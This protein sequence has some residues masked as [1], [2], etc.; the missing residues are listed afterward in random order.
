MS[1]LKIEKIVSLAKNLDSLGEIHSADALEQLLKKI[2]DA[3][4]DIPEYPES[5]YGASKT[6]KVPGSN[7]VVTKSKANQD[8]SSDSKYLNWKKSLDE[9]TKYL[10]GDIPFSWGFYRGKYK[11][12]NYFVSPDKRC[13]YLGK[14]QV[15]GDP[16]TYD[17]ENGK[18]KVISSPD[19][20]KHLIGR[21]FPLD[22]IPEKYLPKRS[23]DK[24]SP[25]ES[26]EKQV[27]VAKSLG[28]DLYLEREDWEEARGLMDQ[29]PNQAGLIRRISTR[30]GVEYI[31]QEMK[32]EYDSWTRLD[33][34][35]IK[36]MNPELATLDL[37]IYLRA[38]PVIENFF[39]E[40]IMNIVE[41]ILTERL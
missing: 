20:K 15:P 25:K 29:F 32:T 5:P 2:A 1:F 22:S 27:Y 19:E 31:L 26:P 23:A 4:F 18:V 9:K 11:T 41:K 7:A 38:H 34:E 33:L 40:K 3:P 37:F 10:T 35:K 24:Q 12:Q 21:L 13:N 8:G 17:L 14:I 30:S 39:S 28:L 6:H 36:I 16:F